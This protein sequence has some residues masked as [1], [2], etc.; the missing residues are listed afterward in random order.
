MFPVRAVMRAILAFYGG[1]LRRDPMTTDPINAM[2]TPFTEHR[3]PRDRGSVHVRDF[4]GSGAA[5]VLLHGFPDNSHIYDDLIPHLVSAGRRT[6]TIDFLGF[7][8]SDKPEGAA[9]SFAQQLGDVEAVV[10]AL[11]LEKVVLVGHDAGGPA[12][13]NFALK[14]PERAAAVVLMNAFYGEAPGLLVPEL[15]QL[16]SHKP[17]QALARHF[18]ASPQQFAWLLDFQRALMLGDAASE[19]KARY[20]DLLGPLIDNNF[21]QQPSAAPAFA[22]MTYQLTDEIAANSARLV[23]LR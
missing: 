22:Q 1:I 16:F 13:V 10:D 11:K 7:G 21:R 19:Q 9:Y 14:H 8:S 18:L 20:R 15:I 3:I 4:V 23:E 17:L 5:F 12:A 6:V 2:S